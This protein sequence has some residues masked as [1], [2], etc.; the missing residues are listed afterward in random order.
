M[1]DGVVR[2][3]LRQFVDE[4]GRTMHMLRRDDPH[5]AAFG[6]IY[7]SGVHFGKVKGWYRHREK[8]LNY[9]VPSGAIRVVIYDDRA[10]SASFGKLEEYRLGESE[11]D[12]AL[13]TIPPFLWYGVQGL[14]PG[15]SIIANCS[16]LP[17]DPAE[18]DRKP[19]DSADVPYAWPTLS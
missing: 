17:N 3:A 12:Y 15:T 13:L 1:I 5:F 4:R 19:I 16:D 9:A 8:T 10:G 18:S 11:G 7:F 14:A 6:E 2:H